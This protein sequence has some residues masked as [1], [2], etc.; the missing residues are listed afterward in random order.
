MLV[1]PPPEPP[2]LYPSNTDV[3]EDECVPDTLR[4]QFN[5]SWREEGWEGKDNIFSWKCPVPFHWRDQAMLCERPIIFV[6]SS[7]SDVQMKLSSLC[8]YVTAESIEHYCH[9]YLPK[10]N[11]IISVKQRRMHWDRLNCTLVFELSFLFYIH[12]IYNTLSLCMFILPPFIFDP[13]ISVKWWLLR[14]MQG[15]ALF[16]ICYVIVL[17][18]IWTNKK[19][20]R[21]FDVD[22]LLIQAWGPV[23][24]SVTKGVLCLLW[25]A[26]LFSIDTILLY[27]C[28][29]RLCV[30]RELDFALFV[31]VYRELSVLFDMMWRLRH[32]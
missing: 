11:C 9:E 14:R 30:G 2:T 26:V 6:S 32:S 23:K 27:F 24:Y 20:L 16:V 8:Y 3:R 17:F 18:H 4:R 12:S 29:L 1:L 22:W 5:R 28:A 31:D 19:V 7:A 13:Q 10:R 25:K 21:F 15:A